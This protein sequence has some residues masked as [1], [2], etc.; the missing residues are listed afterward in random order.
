M[1][2]GG[3]GIAGGYGVAGNYREFV[4]LRLVCQLFGQLS[5]RAKILPCGSDELQ[6][7]EDD[8]AEEG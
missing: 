5:L 8:E 7:D 4:G 6:H 3:L 1:V 2:L